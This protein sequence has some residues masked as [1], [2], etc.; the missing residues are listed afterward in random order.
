LPLLAAELEVPGPGRFPVTSQAL[1][2]V[3][4]K[5]ASIPIRDV[6]PMG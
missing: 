5:P 2:F 4:P 6:P 3:A 1:K